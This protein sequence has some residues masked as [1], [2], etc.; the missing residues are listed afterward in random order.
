[1][2]KKIFKIKKICSGQCRMGIIKCYCESNKI[3]GG[4]RGTCWGRL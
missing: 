1:L 2:I 3:Y 4:R